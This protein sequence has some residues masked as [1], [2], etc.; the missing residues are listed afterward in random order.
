MADCKIRRSSVRKMLLGLPAGVLLVGTALL[1]G[2]AGGQTPKDPP[3]PTPA[4][5]VAALKEIGG[6]SRSSR[7][8]FVISPDTPLKDLLPLAP[9][10]RA[11]PRLIDDISQVPEIAFQEPLAKSPDALK[12]TAHTMAKINHLNRNKTDGFMEAL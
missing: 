4:P 11:G 3:Q 6:L 2:S 5:P 1:G 7:F 12:L 9:K 8:H 10:V